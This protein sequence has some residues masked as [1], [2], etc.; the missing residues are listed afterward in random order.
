M[1]ALTATLASCAGSSER[2][3]VDD[4]PTRYYDGHP[5]PFDSDVYYDP[6]Y[7]LRGDGEF[8]PRYKLK[9]YN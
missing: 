6:T 2:R 9:P 8:R 1:A 3:Y 7:N 4:Y 5:S